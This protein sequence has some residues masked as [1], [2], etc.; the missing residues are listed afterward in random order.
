MTESYGYYCAV[1]KLRYRYSACIKED[2][3]LLCPSGHDLI[4]HGYW[5]YRKHTGSY[6][7]I[8]IS[9]PINRT[10]DK[11]LIK[12]YLDWENFND[13]VAKLKKQHP[14]LIEVI[15]NAIGVSSSISS[16]EWYR[17]CGVCKL[18]REKK[19]PHRWKDIYCRDFVHI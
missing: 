9:K 7:K 6:L 15:D 8:L 16:S 19:C 12:E 17:K 1:C 13:M 3:K 4:K 14:D 2:D 11:I 5:V 18:N 10:Q